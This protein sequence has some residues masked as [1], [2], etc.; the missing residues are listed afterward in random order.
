MHF[1]KYN[2]SEYKLSSQLLRPKRSYFRNY[3]RT[4]GQTDG[5]DNDNSISLMFA[6][7][8]HSMLCDVAYISSE[9]D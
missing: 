6:T 9:V 8:Q 2:G 4:D 3:G 7:L 5:R 1:V